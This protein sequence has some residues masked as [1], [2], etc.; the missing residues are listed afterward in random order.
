[1]KDT[2]LGTLLL[3]LSAPWRIAAITPDLTDKLMT[4]HMVHIDLGA[5]LDN[6]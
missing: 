3:G 2:A 5:V 6:T 1:M 4:I